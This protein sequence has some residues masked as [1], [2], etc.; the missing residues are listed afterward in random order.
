MRTR[1]K[2]N[3][4]DGGEQRRKRV[5]GQERER[6]RGKLRVDG[7]ERKRRRG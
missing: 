3:A 5:R 2:Q 6:W 7:R 4:K 1:E